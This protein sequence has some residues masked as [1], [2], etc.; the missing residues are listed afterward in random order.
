MKSVVPVLAM[1]LDSHL[2]TPGRLS[3]TQSRRH[4]KRRILIVGT[5]DEPGQKLRLQLEKL[6]YFVIGIAPSFDSALSESRFEDPDLV[7]IDVQ[8]KIPPGGTPGAMRAITHIDAPHV[9]IGSRHEEDINQ[10]LLI[11]RPHAFLLAPWSQTDLELAVE[12]ALTRYS[13]EQG[14]AAERSFL[15][16]ALAS[17]TDAVIA[18]TPQETVAWMNSSAEQL[19]G[20]SAA[21]A[22][23]NQL[24]SVCKVDANSVLVRRDGTRKDVDL[25]KSPVLDPAGRSIGTILIL[26]NAVRQSEPNARDGLDKGYSQQ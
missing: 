25:S 23:G 8:A 3:L 2:K 11:F 5:S 15:A 6:G 22:A 7:L 26:N 24:S 9:L 4:S 17:A 21:E 12:L 14:E 13:A 10:L 16:T 19:T 18:I 1:A 20:W